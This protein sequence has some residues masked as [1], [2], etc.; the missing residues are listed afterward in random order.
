MKVLILALFC[1]VSVFAQSNPAAQA[2]KQ[3]RQQHERAIV[4]EFISL[5]SIPNIA[6]DRE[7]IQRNADAI[8]AMLRKRGAEARMVS[9]PGANP[10]IS[11]YR[12]AENWFRCRRPA[13]RSIPNGDC[14]LAGQV[15]TKRRSSR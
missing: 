3:W 6:R 4:D 10:V 1:S 9:I 12:M 11:H 5:L 7:N 8:A 2:A 13:R 14:T 15:M